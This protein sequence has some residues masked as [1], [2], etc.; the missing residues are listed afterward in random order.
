VTTPN[1]GNPCSPSSPCY[2]PV[3]GYGA[4]TGAWNAL[5]NN[6]QSRQVG[7]DVFGHFHI[8]DTR[9]TAFGMFQWLLPNDKVTTDPLDFQRFIVGA[10]YQYNEFLRFAIDSQNVLFYHNQMSMTV[11]ELQKFNY[12]PGSKLNGQF[13]P[14]T[15]SIPYL[16][17]LDTHSI[18]LNVEFS[19]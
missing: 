17:P 4:Q 14:K 16:V 8:P 6:G 18:F 1:F 19:Y 5:L 2:N 9:I 13:L 15:G 11:P 10:S 3:S 7:W 12:V